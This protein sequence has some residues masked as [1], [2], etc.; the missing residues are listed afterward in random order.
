MASITINS[1][2]S[3]L[4]TQRRLD[5][6]STELTK[7]FQRLSSGQ[8]INRASD[9]AAGLAVSDSLRTDSLVYTQGIRNL[10]DGVSMLTIGEGAL[11]ELSSIVIR[12][13]ELAEQA[14]N[15]TFGYQQR[16][17]LDKEAQQLST[18]YTRI[19]QSVE[20]NGS[21][22][23]NGSISSLTFQS[24]Y[25]AAGGI[26]ASVGGVKAAGTFAANIATTN[27]GV[28]QI[29][30]GDL[31]GD[32]ILDV[33]AERSGSSTVQIGLGNGSFGTIVT[34]SAETTGV[35]VDLSDFNNDGNLDIV[36][37]G[38]NAGIQVATVRLGSGN[39][40]FG[41]ATTYSIGTGIYQ[42]VAVGDLNRD[43]NIDLAIVGYDG[44]GGF[45][46][47]RFGQGN[48]TFGAVATYAMDTTQT[49]A[50]ALGDVNNDGNLDLVTAGNSAGAGSMF[51]RYGAG[52]G[53]F[54]SAISYSTESSTSNAV[55]VA[56]ING[57]GLNDI[58]TAG[59]S[60]A[61][62]AATIRLGTGGGA[63][64]A[65]TAYA[66]ETSGSKNLRL[67]DLNGDGAIDLVTSGANGMPGFST[68]RLGN[69]NGSF[70][71]STQLSN[72]TTSGS[73]LAIADINADGALDILSGGVM[74]FGTS[75][76]NLT[77]GVG[78]LI[79]FSLQF[80]YSAIQAMP[81]LTRAL[82]RVSLHR[83]QI[84]S[85]QSRLNSAISNNTS[86]VET[87]TAAES[88]I[89]DADVAQEA[90]QLARNKI[91]QQS[92]TAVLAQANN[93][94]QIALSLLESIR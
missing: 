2:I 42:S 81:D 90:A 18:E 10:N 46:N 53:T 58:A 50:V 93:Q 45:A 19:A 60:G 91:L 76:G 49:S 37:V 40:T 64:S 74:G 35:G 12:L 65:G 86:A 57:D 26:A 21:R 24:G 25:G 73:G 85:Y 7:V 61:A 75:L 55:R 4:Q 89:R 82:D 9:D 67:T 56:D 15:G 28:S 20:F 79:P 17:S 88:Q 83:G 5:H 38:G 71:A 13:K 47:I 59:T 51:V 14:A 3:S 31:N 77:S 23:F 29:A 11:E 43:G 87:F 66:T 36:T 94:P 22:F 44:T 69:G 39:G 92:G 6:S 72:G 41:A 62:G 32:G 1:N 54:N 8:R 80:R 27:A 52:N 63:L 84:G 78:A 16:Q 33:V 68:I 34:Y 30:L 48:G 70:G